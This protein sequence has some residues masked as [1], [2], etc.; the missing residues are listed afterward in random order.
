MGWLE[1]RGEPCRRSASGTRATGRRLWAGAQRHL[2]LG[3]RGPA[4]VPVD[5]DPAKE[6]A[7]VRRRRSSGEY[8]ETHLGDA[9]G[10]EERR[11]VAGLSWKSRLS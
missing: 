2:A 5:H 4:R 6:Q 8:H 9:A 1:P 10:S 11:A 3:I 7:L